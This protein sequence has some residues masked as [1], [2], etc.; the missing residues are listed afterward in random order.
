M[1]PYKLCTLE[2]YSLAGQP[3]HLSCM[4]LL[5]PLTATCYER[6]P[7]LQGKLL[8]KNKTCPART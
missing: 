6:I 8:W 4:V 3:N 1:V 2:P 5:L 7:S